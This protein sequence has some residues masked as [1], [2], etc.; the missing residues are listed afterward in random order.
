MGEV[1][2][3]SVKCP[4]SSNV[5]IGFGLDGLV[6]CLVALLKDKGRES[7]QMAAIFLFFG[8]SKALAL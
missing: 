3:S 4:L 8:I 5:K 1:T 2:P 6:T 7:D